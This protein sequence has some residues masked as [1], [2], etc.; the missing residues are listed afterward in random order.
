[1]KDD[2]SSVSPESRLNGNTQSGSY[3]HTRASEGF[4]K[5]GPIVDF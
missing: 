4:F 2:K 1:M 5:W 3:E